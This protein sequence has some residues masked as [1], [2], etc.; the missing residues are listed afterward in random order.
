M[1]S[2]DGGSIFHQKDLFLRTKIPSVK[3]QKTVFL[4]FLLCSFYF[5]YLIDLD[6]YFCGKQINYCKAGR[7][8]CRKIY[9][10]YFVVFMFRH[11]TFRGIFNFAV[12]YRKAKDRHKVACLYENRRVNW[13]KTSWLIGEGVCQQSLFITLSS[14]FVQIFLA[15][16]SV[17]VP[18]N[19]NQSF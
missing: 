17:S 13:A 19:S 8:K 16:Y 9:F 10:G 12:T 5:A 15:F 2:E 1:Y 11:L 7:T 14:R 18:H 6:F 4:L 3:Y